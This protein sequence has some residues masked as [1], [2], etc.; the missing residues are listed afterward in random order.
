V[1]LRQVVDPEG[2]LMRRRHALAALCP[3]LV[4]LAALGSA[5]GAAAGGG[6]H[7]STE[8]IASEGSSAVVKIDGCTYAPSITRVPVGT[9]VRWVN[10]SGQIHDVTGRRW[11]WQSRALGAGESYARRFT[12]VGVF[13]YSCSLHPG[14]AGMVVVDSP[15]VDA[16]LA[17]DVEGPESES[18]SESGAPDPPAGFVAAGGVG[19]L[20]GTVFGGVVVSRR[21]R[22]PA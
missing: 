3:I 5:T 2:S 17:S 11:Q 18:A 8:T 21:R 22:G 15:A 13:P 4:I 6:C 14:M 16:Q 12:A 20:L 9:E 19:I 7:S 1:Y 10:N